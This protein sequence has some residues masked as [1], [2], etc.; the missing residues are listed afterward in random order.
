MEMELVAALA[1]GLDTDLERG[2]IGLR[3]VQRDAETPE[4]TEICSIRARFQI[5]G[6]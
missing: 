3:Y 4:M 5:P 2:L 1:V 6:F